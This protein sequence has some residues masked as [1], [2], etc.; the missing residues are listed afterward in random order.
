[1][2]LERPAR[3]QLWIAAIAICLLLAS[4]AFAIVRS[5]AI[6][7]ASTPGRSSAVA[8]E[9]GASA[10]D[11]AR[12]EESQTRGAAGTVSVSRRGRKGCGECGIVK[13]VSKIERYGDVGRQDHADV[14]PGGRFHDGAIA[15]EVTTAKNYHV[16]IRFRDGS[17]T[18]LNEATPR[19]WRAG[20]RVIVIAGSNPSID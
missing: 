15:A 19:N 18:A 10:S 5:I 4:A 9:S 20:S 12:I 8:Q 13:S 2:H 17:T 6:S 16:T 3:T 14:R 1:M 11:E 7:F